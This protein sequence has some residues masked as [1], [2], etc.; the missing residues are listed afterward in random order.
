MAATA[1]LSVTLGQVF[2]LIEPLDSEDRHKVIASVMALLGEQPIDSR[3]GGRGFGPNGGGGDVRFGDREIGR[4]ARRWISQHQLD[5]DIIEQV[6]HFDQACVEII[7]AS[8]PGST[9]KQQTG[10]AYLLTGLRALLEKDDSRFTDKEALALCKHLGCY[11][12][13]NHTANRNAIGNKVAGNRQSG[14][15]LPAPGLNAAA[16]VVRQIAKTTQ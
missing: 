16:E 11:D 12:K 14:F 4:T 15:T 3:I 8:V 13:N 10:N 2:E 7:A 1:S 5:A 9:M 6:F